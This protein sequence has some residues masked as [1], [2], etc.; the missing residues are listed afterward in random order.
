MELIY[1]CDNFIT[2]EYCKHL[3]DKFESDENK[4]I[5]STLGGGVNP[6]KKSIDLIINGN[7]KWYNEELYFTRML[8]K[9]QNSYLQ[10]LKS[11]NFDRND[12]L[13]NAMKHCYIFPPQIQ[14]TVPGGY[15]NWHFDT[16]FPICHK[17]FT[18]IIYLNDVDKEFS[19]AT[20]F[21]CGKIIQPKVGKI[22][23]FPST[24]TYLH[25]GRLLESG[26]KYIATNAY[27]C[28]H[29]SLIVPTNNFQMIIR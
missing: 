17:L 3:I 23:I 13:Y 9:A 1:E 14:K 6:I 28:K 12:I 24:L 19:G 20:E 16:S 25:R 21:N 5:G 27:T 2:P 10:F 7:D 22:I 8:Q 18:F 29:P 26:L 4:Q 15:Y 11:G